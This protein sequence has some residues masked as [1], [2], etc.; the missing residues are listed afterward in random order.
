ANTSLAVYD[1]DGRAIVARPFDIQGAVGEAGNDASG[2]ARCLMCYN[3][4]W[5]WS[6]RAGD[7][8]YA[9]PILPVGDTFCRSN[10]PTGPNAPRTSADGKA[11]PGVFGGSSAGNCLGQMRIKDQ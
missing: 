6:Y 10:Q 5:T 11:L 3:N 2:D 9:A 4:V 7:G 1:R 8:L